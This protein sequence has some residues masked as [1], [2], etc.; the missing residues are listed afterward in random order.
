MSGPR[1]NS[2]MRRTIGSMPS[3]PSEQFTPTAWTPSAE[4]VMAAISGL[5]PKN[6]QPSSPKVMLARIGRSQ[7]SLQA[8]T[9]ALVSSRSVM[10]S[11]ITRSAPYLWAARACSA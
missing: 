7:L 5:V 9:A 6:V 11:T 8:R 4:S 2:A 3:G 1:E 10:V